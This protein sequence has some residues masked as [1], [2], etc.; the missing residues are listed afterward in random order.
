MTNIG[1]PSDFLFGVATS[2]YQIEG[3]WN[4]A[5][6]GESIWDRFAHAP[7]NIADGHTGDVACDHYHRFAEDIALMREMKVRA[8]RFSVSWPR[9]LPEGKGRVNPAGL[10]FYSRLVDALLDA[11]IKPVL[12]LFHWDL[13][14]ALQ[15]IGGFANRDV[16]GWFS[17]YAALL[18][19]RLGD[20]VK[21]W[22]TMN[23]PSVFAMLGHAIGMHAPGVKDYLT[24]FKVAHHLNLA[25]GRAVVAIRD[26]AS[27]VE[28]G[29]AL[30]LP[31]IHPRTN[32]EEDRRA[33]QIGRAS[34][35]ERV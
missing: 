16:T 12:N 17:D 22:V 4:E 29:A 14:Q 31:A 9:A 19:S 27:G 28:V 3:A 20:R 25:H 8:Y 18:A 24:Y 26:S 30:S 15:D 11:G 33:A 7:G 35:R 21:M 6:K 5:G 32:T 1:F 10:D 23:E 2:S 34:C 13:P